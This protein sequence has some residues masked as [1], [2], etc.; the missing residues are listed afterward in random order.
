MLSRPEGTEV[1]RP[2]SILYFRVEDIQAGFDALS[3]RKVELLD[4][5]HLIARM[6]DHDLWMAFFKDSEGNTLALMSELRNE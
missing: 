1:F 4:E 5:P 2:G 3:A 6:S